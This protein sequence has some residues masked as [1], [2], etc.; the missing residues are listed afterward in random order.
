MDA[1]CRRA[2]RRPGYTRAVDAPFRI[3]EEVREALGAGRAVVALETSVVAHGLPAPHGLE[4]A[5][6]CA[7]AVRAAGAVP[8]AVAVLGGAVVV[9]ASP[10]ELARLA[11]GTARAAKG[12]AR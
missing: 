3:A 5:R 1:P 9:G 2:S 12:A 6:R 7:E 10:A 4:A 11:G 8:A